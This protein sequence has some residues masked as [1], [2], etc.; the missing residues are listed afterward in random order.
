MIA[1]AI[2]RFRQRLRGLGDDGHK[3]LG[4]HDDYLDKN[5]KMKFTAAVVQ[6][7]TNRFRTPHLMREAQNAS[8]RPALAAAVRLLSDINL[9][10]NAP[11]QK[12][13]NVRVAWFVLRSI[14]TT[15]K[16]PGLRI[17]PDVST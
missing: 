2:R 3:N 11:M 9:A 17:K 16:A 12:C 7:C 4:A 13:D 6:N 8:L 15:G 14:D 5:E 10:S 1:G